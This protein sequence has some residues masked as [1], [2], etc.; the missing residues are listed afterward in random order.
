MIMQRSPSRMR[1]L[2]DEPPL[3]LGF[4]LG[5][6]LARSPALLY[7]ALNYDESMYLLR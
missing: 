4:I 5:A 6:I 1:F 2:S 7:S 3:A